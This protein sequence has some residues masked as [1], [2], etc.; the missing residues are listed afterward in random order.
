MD[1]DVSRHAG[2]LPLLA[3]QPG[4]IAYLLKERVSNTAV[5]VDTLRRGTEGECVTDPTIVR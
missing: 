3:D 5:L 1:C 2:G 4:A